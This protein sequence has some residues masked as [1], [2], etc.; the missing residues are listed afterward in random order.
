L[1][2][3]PLEAGVD[4][5]RPRAP[6]TGRQWVDMAVAFCAIAISVISLFIAVENGRTER[7]LVAASSWPFLVFDPQE[8]GLA[9]GSRITLLRVENSGVGPARVQ[10]AIVRLDGKPVR[11]RIELLSRCCGMSPASDPDRQVELGLW[12]QNSVVGVIPAREGVNFLGLRERSGNEKLWQ[13]F[14]LAAHRLSFEVCYCSVLDECWRTDLAS[15]TTPTPVRRCP[16]RA[17]GYAG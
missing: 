2:E 4:E 1:A 3:P 12:A 17:D 10:S 15:T 6:R 11:S 16:P 13:A 5:V 7:R 8:Q 9:R 14:H